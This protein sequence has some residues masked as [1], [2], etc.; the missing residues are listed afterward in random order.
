VLNHDSPAEIRTLLRQLGIRLQKRWGQNFLVSPGARAKIVSLID[1]RPGELIWEV[2]PGLG[3]LTVQLAG[4]VRRLLAFEIDQGLVRFLRGELAPLP[5]VTL[6]AG[7]VLKR[8]RPTLQEEGGPDK[9]VGN[10]P[11]STAS[12]LIGSLA[13]ARVR[14]ERMVFTVQKEL[15]QRMTARPGTKSY[16]SFSILCQTVYD[17]RERFSLRPGSFFPAPAVTSSVVELTPAAVGAGRQSAVLEAPEDW[18]FFL[19]LL[20]LL[21]SSRRKTIRNNLLA[22]GLSKRESEEEL[23]Q[24][25]RAAGI[26]PAGRAEG[27]TPEQLWKLAATLRRGLQDL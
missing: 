18:A 11:Y 19:R 27:L 1:P 17:V 3:S 21:F 7:D 2:G 20:R 22:A 9:I 16:S 14:P 26:D 13:E 25:V 15:A 5:N 24:V 10:L 6:V 4:R 23:L 12:A 8:W